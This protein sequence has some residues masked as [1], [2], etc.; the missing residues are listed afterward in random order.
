M[1]PLKRLWHWID[2]RTGFSETIVPLA[3]HPVPPET[4]SKK[5]WLYVFGAGTLAAFINQ[6][7]TGAALTTKYIPS[8]A[9]AYQS[10]EFITN[11]IMF[12]RMLRGMHYF[13]A[14]AMVLFVSLHMIRVFM[15][16]SYK[17]PREMSWISGIGLLFLTLTMAWTGQLLR[18]DQ[19]GVWTVVV[20]TKFAARFPLIGEPAATFVLGGETVGGATLSRFFSFHVFMIPALIITL[21]GFHLYLVVRNGISEWP[22]AG[23]PVDP[24][25]YTG[26]YHEMI[27]RRGRPHWPD[28]AWREILV[29]SG[30]IAGIAAL[31]YLFGP[32]ALSA[33]PDP[34]TLLTNPQPD[35]YFRW[36]YALLAYKPQPL[37]T[38]TMVYLPAL[39]AAVLFLLPLVAP[40]G[41]RSIRHRPWAPIIVVVSL[42]TLLGL[43][44][45]GFRAPWVP[46]AE[47][48]VL[49][50]EVLGIRTSLGSQGARTYYAEGCQYCHAIAGHGG[51]YGPDLTDVAKRL[52]SSEMT[53]RIYNGYREMPAYRDILSP[54]EVVAIVAFLMELSADDVKGIENSQTGNELGFPARGTSASRRRNRGRSSSASI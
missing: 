30:V 38:F 43:T 22:R 37:T 10:L 51:Q 47:T 3:K 20:G 26:W 49:S 41:E 14:S 45:A 32:R 15:T 39:I 21:V 29:G 52:S 7:I 35:W 46:P 44:I 9:H 2:V 31:A 36:Y 19:N 4:A 5:G 33:P 11:E 23:R 8:T 25:T 54:E 13:G 40:R 16:G 53:I 6:V 24:K 28:A 34:T 12:G 42:T 17:F 48:E 1:S 27:E 18:W 50:P